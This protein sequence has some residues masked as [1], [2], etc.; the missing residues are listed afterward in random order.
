M[1][2]I[3]YKGFRAYYVDPTTLESLQ[4][5]GSF[6][7][8]ICN[9]D[10]DLG[11]FPFAFGNAYV[12]YETARLQ[13][14][15]PHGGWSYE[16]LSG[17]IMPRYEQNNP[18]AIQ[19][20]T[21]NVL[22]VAPKA[23]ANVKNETGQACKVK[24]IGSNGS[25]AISQ[26]TVANNAYG[27]GTSTAPVL[28]DLYDEQ[29]NLVKEN[30]RLGALAYYINSLEIIFRFVQNGLLRKIS[31]GDVLVRGDF[32]EMV[33]IESRDELQQGTLSGSVQ[34]QHSDF[35]AMEK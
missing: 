25:Y 1:A 9:I 24:I 4:F 18:S 7:W 12:S 19:T 22:M 20:A 14:A 21:D 34:A 31:E 28:M 6:E 10:A 16:D 2:R 5:A 15:G 33:G 17:Y 3:E 32:S 23:R 35:G 8:V 11:T 26:V 27:F 13:L 29:G 30:S